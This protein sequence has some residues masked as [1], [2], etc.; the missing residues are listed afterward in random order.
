MAK[1]KS[2]GNQAQFTYDFGIHIAQSTVGKL[3]KLTGASLTLASAFYALKTNAN[4]YVDT[5]RTNTLRFG[6]ILSTMKAMEQAQNRLIKGQSYFKVGDQLEGMNRL[7]ASGIKV[8][9][10]LEW[11]NKAAHATGKSFS[12]FSDIISQGIQ[13]N[14]QGLVDM[15]L[16]TQRATR[17]FE[18]YPANTIM[19]Q[20]AILNF[21]KTHKGL[22][23]AI[24]NDFVTVQ[25]QILRIKSTWSGFIKSIVGKPN[26]PNSF[27]GQ[28][29]SSL[30]MIADAFSRN[31]ETMKK[32][33]FMIGQ[34]L[35]WVIKQVG[36]FIVWVGRQ[37][38]KAI[39]SV[40]DVTDNFKDQTRSLLVWL[41]FW[42]LRITDFFDSYGSQIK[43]IIKWTLIFKGLKGAFTFSKAA[44]ASAAAYNSA[45]F[46]RFG[47]FTKIG[48]IKR[49]VGTSWWKAFWAAALPRWAT[50][51]LTWIS[52]FVQ[53]TL[54]KFIGKAGGLLR[55]IGGYIGST[56][57]GKV[58]T[59][60]TKFLGVIG[61]MWSVWEVLD[62]I[63]TKVKFIGDWTS[64]VKAGVNKWK[65]ALT[66][67]FDTFRFWWD[68][69]Y[70][71]ADKHFF[72]PIA[73][74]WKSDGMPEYFNSLKNK[75]LDV[76]KT[77]A[78]ALKDFIFGPY[79]K[80]FGWI[81][82]WVGERRETYRRN[83]QLNSM[84]AEL[85]QKS[86][87]L[88]ELKRI[89][90]NQAEAR[91]RGLPVSNYVVPKWISDMTAAQKVSKE[92]M[93]AIN[94]NANIPVPEWGGMGRYTP[95]NSPFSN[96]SEP[97][98]TPL[99]PVA[100]V[101]PIVEEKR[102]SS[103]SYSENMD[104]SSAS[105]VV[106]SSGGIQ[107]IVQ[108]GDNIDETKLARKIREVIQDLQRGEKVRGGKI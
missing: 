10:N 59:V 54:P 89:R 34:T 46:G 45:L 32:Y 39:Q 16:I 84:R 77:I 92:T 66:D 104:Y 21:V 79:E 78:K 64:E 26:D 43:S 55:A 37:A 33:G 99:A 62:K 87:D 96:I 82:D 80:A 24:R 19:R 90:S 2:R 17:V 48:R 106:I 102:K 8:G 40:W 94:P 63:G 31:F 107:I 74:R 6:G 73:N 36:H 93:A 25:D 57:S 18:K 105:D 22:M 9:E 75:A 44:I 29:T 58:A 108:K 70:K 103:P 3:T 71:W 35:G 67:M 52:R 13:G 68:D 56:F 30:K 60:G 41:E 28:L 23:S 100:P 95:E 27:Y 1:L 15:G 7:M 38:K 98:V 101:N 5:L 97:P 86:N 69:A 47:F 12:Q 42:K 49:M 11:I 53:V 85:T 72:T 50:K 14:M 51:S 65:N 76:I 81:R 88:A 91:R 20:Q 61:I 4:E 83:Q